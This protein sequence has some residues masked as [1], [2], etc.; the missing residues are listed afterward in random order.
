M[1]FFA[2]HRQMREGRE[3]EGGIV[4]GIERGERKKERLRN[5]A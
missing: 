5:Q 3:G 4:E 2:S 1:K